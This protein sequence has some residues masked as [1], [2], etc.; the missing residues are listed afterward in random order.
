MGTVPRAGH[1]PAVRTGTAMC[2]CADVSYALPWVVPAPRYRAALCILLVQAGDYVAKQRLA[3]MLWGVELP[4][5]PAGALRTC[6]YSRKS[7][8][9]PSRAAAIRG[10]TCR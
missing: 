9:S 5:D 3:D 6:I 8:G 7:L 10:L 2:K 4:G 1:S